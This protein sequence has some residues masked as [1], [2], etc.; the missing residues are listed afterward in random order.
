MPDPQL[1]RFKK[2]ARKHCLCG[3]A[4]TERAAM[5][6]PLDPGFTSTWDQQSATPIFSKVAVCCGMLQSSYLPSI[7]YFNHRWASPKH[8]EALTCINHIDQWS[9]IT[10]SNRHRLWRDLVCLCT[11]L[12]SSQAISASTRMSNSKFGSMSIKDYCNCWTRR[13]NSISGAVQQK[14]WKGLGHSGGLAGHVERKKRSV[15]EAS[16]APNSSA[17]SGWPSWPS[18]PSSCRSASWTAAKMLELQAVYSFYSVWSES[19]RCFCAFENQ[20]QGPCLNILLDILLWSD[21]LRI[22]DCLGLALQQDYKQRH[23]AHVIPAMVQKRHLIHIITCQMWCV[24]CAHPDGKDTLCGF[25]SLLRLYLHSGWI[26]PL[27][28]N[29]SIQLASA[30]SSTGSSLISVSSTA[31]FIIADFYCIFLKR[32]NARS[33]GMITWSHAQPADAV[34]LILS[35]VQPHFIGRMVCKI[36]NQVLQSTDSC[37][38]KLRCL[39][40]Y[41]TSFR[42]MRSF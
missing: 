31:S 9:D 3:G 4:P 22:K 10:R 40:C 14:S 12:R 23:E 15:S 5:Y 11:E 16:S 34:L 20:W 19:L 8:A 27:A 6:S 2:C 29:C 1:K 42:V 37:W 30:S 13:K 39:R 32:C 33:C 18:W 24:R 38:L 28:K 36:I 26:S 21:V 7:T 25:T 41:L 35:A 17:W